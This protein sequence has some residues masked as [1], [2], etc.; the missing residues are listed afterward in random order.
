MDDR[1]HALVRSGNSASCKLCGSPSL[2]DAYPFNLSAFNHPVSPRASGSKSRNCATANRWE[3]SNSFGLFT[4][5]RRFAR[6][7]YSTS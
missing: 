5:R 7:E 3:L 1:L 4:S 2:R 6:G